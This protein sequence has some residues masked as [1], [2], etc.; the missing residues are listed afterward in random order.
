M[1]GVPEVVILSAQYEQPLGNMEA[2]LRTYLPV[3]WEPRWYG[4]RSGAEESLLKM[5][6]TSLSG[7]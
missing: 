7:M 5:W 4:S 2:L 3:T 1:S 6:I